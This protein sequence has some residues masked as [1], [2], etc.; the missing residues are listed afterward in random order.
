MLKAYSEPNIIA[1]CLNH[2]ADSFTIRKNNTN[3]LLECIAVPVINGQEA[4]VLVRDISAEEMARNAQQA[5]Q[6]SQR[7]EAVGK[8]A[9]GVA[10]DL[11]NLLTIIVALSFELAQDLED[12]EQR[13]DAQEIFRAAELA[14]EFTQKLR[15]LAEN[16]FRGSA[17]RDNGECRTELRI[18]PLLQR[19]V[20]DNISLNV[21]AHLNC[22]A[23]WK[24]ARVTWNK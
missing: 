14:A 16:R 3:H 18:R 21:R 13:E 7:M 20:P 6:Q 5:L 10:H 15:F 4:I 9:G 2:Q 19:L 23:G 1:H 24:A 11:N 8:L 17:Y 12:E 22:R